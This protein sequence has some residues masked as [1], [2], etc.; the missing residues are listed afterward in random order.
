MMHGDTLTMNWGALEQ[1]LHDTVENEPCCW[2]NDCP[3]VHAGIRC[4]ADTCSCWHP[5]HDDTSDKHKKT[6]ETLS[7]VASMG[8]EAIQHRCGNNHGEGDCLTLWSGQI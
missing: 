5:G 7:D 6:K 8:V 1:L 2:G 3:C 4:Q